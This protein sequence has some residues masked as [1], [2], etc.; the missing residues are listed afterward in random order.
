MLTADEAMA[1][2]NRLAHGFPGAR[3][4]GHEHGADGFDGAV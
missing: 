2:P 4:G 3:A 1:S